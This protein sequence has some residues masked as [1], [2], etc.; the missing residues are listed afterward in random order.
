M[1]SEQ[2][3]STREERAAA[4]AEARHSTEMEGGR[5]GPAAR[6]L[7]DRYVNGEFDVDELGRRTRVLYGLEPGREEDQQAEAVSAVDDSDREAD[8]LGQHFLPDAL[9]DSAVATLNPKD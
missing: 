7:Q 8:E 9:I 1:T 6:E 3:S 5:S 4:V 2:Q